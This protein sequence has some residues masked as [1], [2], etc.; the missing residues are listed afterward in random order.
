MNN[1]EHN[2]IVWSAIRS[3][4]YC[5]ISFNI[6][7][8]LNLNPIIITEIDKYFLV[9]VIINIYAISAIITLLW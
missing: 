8:Y 3:I 2:K 4:W 7:C 1:N 9:F 5:L 6:I